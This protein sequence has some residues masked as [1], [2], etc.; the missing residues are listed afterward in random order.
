LFAHPPPSYQ[1]F[2]DH[3]DFL[4]EDIEYS[5]MGGMSNHERVMLFGAM[6]SRHKGYNIMDP[7]KK[8]LKLKK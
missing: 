1:I 8:K 6:V 3:H 7:K 5:Q 2:L 4:T